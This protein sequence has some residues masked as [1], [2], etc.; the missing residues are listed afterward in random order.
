MVFIV[1]YTHKEEWCDLGYRPLVTV[2]VPVYNEEKHIEKTINALLRQ[3][4][5]KNKLQIIVV[6]DGSTDKTL[7]KIQWY[8]K[9]QII[10]LENNGGKRGAIC[11]A[12]QKVKGEITVLIDSDSILCPCAIKNLVQPFVNPRVGAATG[13][14][15]IRNKNKNLLTR[16]QDVW[17]YTMLK[18]ERGTQSYFRSVNCC[19]GA[20]A[21]Y[22]TKILKEKISEF[23]GATFLGRRFIYGDDRDLTNCVLRDNDVVYVPQAIS[24]TV[25]P[26][27]ISMFIKQQIRWKKGWFK[28]T[29]T[30]G[31][32]MFKKGF[33]ATIFFYFR[34]L[35]TVLSPI[36]I[37][38][39]FLYLPLTYGILPI[40]YV[41][42]L[43]FFGS[44]FG[45]DYK[46][47]VRKNKTWILR[48]FFGIIFVPFMTL[49]L[50]YAILSLLLT[51]QYK[52]G[53]R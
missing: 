26:Q 44:I 33:F 23:K 51:K 8:D 31:R 43:F 9:I 38:H 6:N 5:P 15:K 7:E 22:R 30:A 19:S 39:N 40:I 28:G 2:I 29:L 32:F 1:A 46:F 12:L 13:N 45:I 36:V 21:S 42:G 52:W 3:H 4:Y 17:Y 35:V 25:V 24:Y 37:F 47:H 27:T 16:F 50:P 48:P 14:I 18:F 49:L 10:N 20:I 53:T 11:R 41:V 34:V